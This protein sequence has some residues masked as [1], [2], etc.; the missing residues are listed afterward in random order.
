VTATSETSPIAPV[1]LSGRFVRLEPLGW[2]HLEGLVAS[3]LDPALYQWT[4]D[5]VDS[6]EGMAEKVRVAL[7][8]AEAGREVPFASVEVASG[9]VIG[10]TRFMAIERRHRRAE[11]GDTRVGLAWQRTPVNTEAKYLMLRQAFEVWELNRVE[12]KADA[13]NAPSRA[14]LARLGAVEEGTF[15]H[16]MVVQGGESATRCIMRSS[17][18]IGR[19]FV[20]DSK[21]SWLARSPRWL[22]PR[23]FWRFF[24]TK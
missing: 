5:R 19:R 11:I 6:A 17:L 15:R 12:F 16:H 13:L 3:G 22:D 23:G 7:E 20:P 1:T 24:G 9:K 21:L 8:A 10:S 2:E 18:R 4:L 14:A